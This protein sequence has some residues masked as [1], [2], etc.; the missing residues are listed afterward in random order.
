MAKRTFDEISEKMEEND[1][2]A[3]LLVNM[4]NI[5]NF[6][7]SNNSDCKIPELNDVMDLIPRVIIV[8]PQSSGK[9]SICNKMFNLYNKVKTGMG[10]K[11]P[12]E[13]TFSPRSDNT[14]SV[15]QDNTQLQNFTNLDISS[16]IAYKEN[17]EK[18]E[19][20]VDLS[21]NKFYPRAA[22]KINK[23]YT[24][25]FSL[26][27]YPGFIADDGD[28]NVQNNNN[29]MYK[30]ITDDIGRPQT[31]TV[32]VMKADNDIAT[33]LSKRH[34]PKNAKQVIAI[35]HVDVW[36]H[37][38][39]KLSVLYEIIK[40]NPYKIALICGNRD[41]SA[42]EQKLI[43]D[44][45][46]KNNI[47]I[48][49]LII[50]TEALRD[51]LIDDLRNK[52][53][54][55]K[56]M[57]MNKINIAY[58]CVNRDLNLIGGRETPD[59][60]LLCYQFRTISQNI[61]GQYFKN[62]FYNEQLDL[63]KQKINIKFFKKIIDEDEIDILTL[64]KLIKNSDRSK[65]AGTQETHNI[66]LEFLNEK[67][68]LTIDECN[69]IIDEYFGLLAIHINNILQNEQLSS[70]YQAAEFTNNNKC[71]IVN[72]IYE[73]KEEIKKKF[74]TLVNE[75][76]QKP[77][78]RNTFPG[79]IPTKIDRKI[80]ESFA[81]IISANPMIINDPS[82]LNNIITK[83]FEEH[84]SGDNI[85]L[86]R[87]EELKNHIISIWGTLSATFDINLNTM[88]TSEDNNII[89]FAKERM[90]I[91]EQTDLKEDVEKMNRR[92]LLLQ[93]KN[94]IDQTNIS[95]NKY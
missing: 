61:L 38:I 19:N 91:I 49:N 48:D 70:I 26:T 30:I 18:I 28:V 33:D 88:L 89:E 31:I 46:K 63:I 81:R 73:I 3:D 10:T 36:A 4:S 65:I 1:V 44:I 55:L 77:E 52:V 32:R 53:I 45:I 82:K 47:K 54:E 90:A 84:Y 21:E 39:S 41:S 87:A 86:H 22:L 9:S 58:Y 11:L 6:I 27:D 51:F 7:N 59:F 37:D 79:K 42:E 60:K 29:L 8:G 23:K 68:L 83:S 57:F 72:K 93:L 2:Y 69:I 62:K 95:L 35:S 71:L 16:E 34:I 64:S 50:G 76:I 15:Y 40:L 5:G 85:Y 14:M 20:N 74:K 13:Y 56:P 75:H 12:I 78:S 25:T 94:A 43:N 67:S 17:I 24:K 92:A 80:M 66:I